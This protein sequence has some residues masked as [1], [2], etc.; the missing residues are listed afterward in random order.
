VYTEEAAITSMKMGLKGGKEN[1]VSFGKQ[2]DE[3]GQE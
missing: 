3:F 1:W 2:S